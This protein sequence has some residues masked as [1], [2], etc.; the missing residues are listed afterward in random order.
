MST[1]LPNVDWRP[2]WPTCALCGKPV[3][4]MDR[5]RDYRSAEVIFIVR[6]HG[7]VDTCRIDDMMMEDLE[8]KLEPGFAFVVRRLPT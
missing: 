5:D 1:K 7:D 4:R 8:G 2:L 6:C 3:E